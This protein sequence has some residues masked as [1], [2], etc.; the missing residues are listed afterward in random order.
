[1][2]IEKERK[3]L[4]FGIFAPFGLL[5]MVFNLTFFVSEYL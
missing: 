5:D 2:N 3:I 4:G 1:M